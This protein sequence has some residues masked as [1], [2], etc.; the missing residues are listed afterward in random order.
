MVDLHLLGGDS[1]GAC[2][3]CVEARTVV[4]FGEGVLADTDET[5]FFET[6]TRLRLLAAFTRDRDRYRDCF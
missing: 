3:S 1:D 2:S 5:S 4:F 6:D